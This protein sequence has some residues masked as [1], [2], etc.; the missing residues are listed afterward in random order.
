MEKEIL[1]Q[2]ELEREEI[3]T[4]MCPFCYSPIDFVWLCKMHNFSLSSYIYICPKCNNLL[5]FS[6]RK[7]FHPQ[8][9]KF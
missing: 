6:N 9:S 7:G 3:D 2:K 1:I 5:N 4:Y 8:S